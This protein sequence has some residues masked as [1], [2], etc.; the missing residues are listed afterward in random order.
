QKVLR[1]ATKGYRH[2]PQLTRFRESADPLAAIAAYLRGVYEEAEHRGYSF[3]RRKIPHLRVSRR[4]KETR[5]QLLCEWRHLQQ[6]LKVRDR[7]RY[8]RHRSLK[9]LAPHPMFRIVA[10]KVR[11]WE[12]LR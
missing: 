10:G 9:I 8:D 2:H 11:S 7:A 3:D 12:R 1:G 6:K 4:M 5:G